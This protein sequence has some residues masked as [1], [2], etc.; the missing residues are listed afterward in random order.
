MANPNRLEG[1]TFEKSSCWGVKSGLFLKIKSI[2][3]QNSNISEISRRAV[4]ESFEGRGLAM[5][6][7][8]VQF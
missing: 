6:V 2:L 8:D 1:H 4:L 3:L 7:I 5:V